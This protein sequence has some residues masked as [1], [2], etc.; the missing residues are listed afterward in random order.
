MSKGMRSW[1]VPLIEQVR[2]RK[3]RLLCMAVWGLLYAQSPSPLPEVYE[4]LRRGLTLNAQRLLGRAR[5]HPDS[6]VRQEAALLQGYLAAKG[7]REKNALSEWYALSQRSPYS[8]YGMEATFWRAELL[9]RQHAS[10]P[11]GLYL[12]RTLVEN[13]A[14]PPDLRAA[15]ERR[16]AYF[17]WRECDLGTLWSYAM[18]GTPI[19]YP[20]VLPPL[21]YH[22][23]QSCGWRLWRLWEAFHARTCGT[24]PDSLR[25]DFLTKDAPLETLRVALLLPLMAQQERSSPFL[26]FWQGFALGLSESLSPYSTWEVQVEDSERNPI[27]IQELLSRW[28]LK[29]P[30]I[31]VGE[32]SWSLNQPIADFC[33][34]KGI[35]HAVPINPAYPA[36][37][38]SIP[39][40]PSA[41]CVGW[42]L[43]D[44]YKASHGGRGVLLYEAE[45]PQG[46]AIVEGFRRRWWVPAYPLPGSLPELIRRWNTLR[47]SLGP[48]DWYGLFLSQEELVGFLLHN[49]GQ[50]I[51]DTPL[52]IGMESWLLFTRTNLKDYRRVRLWVPQSLLPDSA[53]WSRLVRKVREQ[54]AQRPTLFHAQGYDA[55]RLL[56]QLSTDYERYR[57]PVTEY[58]GILNTYSVPPAC[59]RYRLRIWEYEQGEIRV[60]Y[61]P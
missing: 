40:I 5:E 60:R 50:K 28:A 42:Q 51:P 2:S 25:L 35:W 14:T 12:L 10:Q 11:A 26:E 4:A 30:D 49:I 31:I 18:E 41:A 27:R 61:G 59:D 57:L 44:F 38:T 48:L 53:A 39:L 36:R 6:L 16:L 47:D 45:D 19:L 33:E 13:P 55:A 1:R 17:F 46:Q 54:Y 7:G 52:V 43:A 21:L 29:P 3:I 24:V 22:L 20:Y 37:R 56:S 32:V 8:P 34:R 58:N 23:R 15:V 9:L